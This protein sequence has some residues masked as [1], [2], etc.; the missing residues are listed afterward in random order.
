MHWRFTAP[1]RRQEGFIEP[2]LPTLG[3]TVPTGPQWAYEIKHDGFRFICRREGDRVQHARAV[4]CAALAVLT[5][6]PVCEARNVDRADELFAFLKI[7]RSNENGYSIVLQSLS[8]EFGARCPFDDG[9]M[10]LKGIQATFF[11]APKVRF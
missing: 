1:A 2:C 10:R 7:G 6:R 3:H 4:R 5:E 11:R 9:P 8:I